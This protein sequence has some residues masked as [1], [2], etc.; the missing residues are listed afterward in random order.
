MVA[1]GSATWPSTR[2]VTLTVRNRGR[3]LAI[4]TYCGD[5]LAER[6]SQRLWVNGRL[7]KGPTHCSFPPGAGYLDM[8]KRPRSEKTTTV[9]VRLETSIPE[10]LRRP[11]TLTVAVYDGDL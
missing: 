4:V 2:E 7:V 6:L 11:G 1:K 9:R 10:Y 8:G 5:G 3:G